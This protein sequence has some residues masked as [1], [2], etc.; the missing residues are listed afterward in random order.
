MIKKTMILTL[1]GLIGLGFA[2]SAQ[3]GNDNNSIKGKWSLFVQGNTTGM[4]PLAPAGTPLIA[5][6]T[7]TFDGDGN[8]ESIDQII[9][10]GQYI[11]S[12]DGFRSTEPDG[13]CV[14]QVN[15][16]GTG[17]FDVSFPGAGPTTVTFVLAGKDELSFIA[18][19]ESLG[20]FGGGK[21]RKMN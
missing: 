1:A 5:V 13:G 15:E 9:L 2:L 4:S 10:N 6:A 14:Y 21:M 18:N 3:A 11:P 17:F 7:V 20:I 8:C 19:N 12:R 16:D